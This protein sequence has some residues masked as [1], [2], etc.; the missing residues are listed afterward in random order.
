MS[1]RFALGPV[2]YAFACVLG[3][4]N[5]WLSIGT[6]VCLIVFYMMDSMAAPRNGA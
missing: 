2:L 1:L 6:Y 3:A 5:A 4:I